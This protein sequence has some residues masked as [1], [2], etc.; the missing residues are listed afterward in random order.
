MTLV[1]PA[2]ARHR[3]VLVRH[4]RPDLERGA[5]L[6][7]GAFQRFIDA[8]QEAGL[9][10][11][12]DPPADL[13]ALVRGAKRVFVSDL[14]RSIE[15]AARLL[16]DAESISDRLFTEVPL[17]SPPL[18]G[19][20]LKVPAWAVVARVAWHGGYAPG[21]ETWA[22]ARLRIAR[23]FGLV[24]RTARRDGYAVVVAHGYF[25]AMLGRLLRLR[26]W[27]RTHGNHR[28]EFW[29]VVVYDWVDGSAP[30]KRLTRSSRRGRTRSS[31]GIAGRP[32]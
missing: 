30:R 14:P 8:Y 19:L 32:T 24:T 11:D 9:A 6:N 27:R 5:W 22:Q 16:P 21:I 25:N 17:V 12:S 3:I 31:K 18:R 29:N 20:R 2:S 15:S 10:R 4:G 26:G 28:A 23:A 13:S 1:R 7:A